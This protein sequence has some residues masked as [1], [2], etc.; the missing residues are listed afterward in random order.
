MHP[1]VRSSR[2]LTLALKNGDSR[3][4]LVLRRSIAL[5]VMNGVQRFIAVERF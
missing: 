2:K 4:C 1:Y 3:F 5:A